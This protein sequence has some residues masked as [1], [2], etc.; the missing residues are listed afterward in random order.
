ML[1]R[2]RRLLPAT[3]AATLG[4]APALAKPA[5]KKAAAHAAA[6]KVSAPAAEKQLNAVLEKI[7]QEQLKESPQGLTSLGLDKGENAWAKSWLDDGSAAAI[8]R[9]IGLQKGWLA[10]VMAVPRARLGGG[11]AVN[12][13]TVVYQAEVGLGGAERFKYGAPGYPAPYVLSQLTGAYQSI[14][15]FLDSQHS[16][17]TKA[18]AEAYL[19][20]LEGF[21]KAMNDETDQTHHDTNIN[22][23]P[24]DFVIDKARGRGG[25]RRAAPRGRAARGAARGRRAG[26]EN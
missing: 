13:D 11:A 19:S 20:R 25:A 5:A 8:Q 2:R 21:A 3:A 17:E 24:P 23:A 15:D 6:R 16:I 26:R 14:P 7:F 22:V 10:E 9:Y 18:D 12:Y 4:A 1:D